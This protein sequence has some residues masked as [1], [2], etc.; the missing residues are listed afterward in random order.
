MDILVD[1]PRLQMRKFTLDDID[2][3][4]EFSAHPDVVRYTGDAGLVKTKEDAKGIIEDIWLK[5]YEQYGYARYALIHKEDNRVIGFCG[6]KYE[7][8]LGAP[9]IG[10]RMLPEYWGQGLGYEAASTTLEFAK[11]TLGLE[12]IV[13]EVAEENIG[14]WKILEKCGMQRI[15]EYEKM[16]FRIYFYEY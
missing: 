12:R 4:F 3:V 10:Y 2:A 6:V 11:H 15:D 8:D 1:T 9:D 14:S 13:G 7:P 16:G 5:E